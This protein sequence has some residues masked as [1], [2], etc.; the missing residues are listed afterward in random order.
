MLMGK[1]KE[2]SSTAAAPAKPDNSAEI[3]QLKQ[4]LKAAMDA[5][6]FEK[7]NGLMAKIKDLEGK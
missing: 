4:D 3:K 5:G 1:I 2:A 6:D 7:A